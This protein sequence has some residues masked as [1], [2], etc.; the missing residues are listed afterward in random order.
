MSG[1]VKKRL[2]ILLLS[3]ACALAIT[4]CGKD[5]EGEWD[6]KE[7]YAS[8][9]KKEAEAPEKMQTE[10]VPVQKSGDAPLAAEEAPAETA[11]PADKEE[12]IPGEEDSAVSR[13]DYCYASMLTLISRSEDMAN[14]LGIG[15]NDTYLLNSD[16]SKME[17]AVADI[18]GDGVKELLVAYDNMQADRPVNVYRFGSLVEITGRYVEYLREGWA[19]AWYDESGQAGIIRDSFYSVDASV[20]VF[21]DKNEFTEWMKGFWEDISS[22]QVDENTPV[23]VWYYQY[24]SGERELIGIFNSEEHRARLKEHYGETVPLSWLPMTDE[25][26]RALVRGKTENTAAVLAAEEYNTP[27][28]RYIYGMCE[29][30]G[31]LGNSEECLRAHY[32]E[33]SPDSVLVNLMFWGAMEVEECLPSAKIVSEEDNL[34]TYRV[35]EEDFQAWC[36]NAFA[37]YTMEDLKEEEYF[38]DNG[39]GTRQ[40]AIDW[41]NGDGDFFKC[42]VISAEKRGNFIL[43]KGVVTAHYGEYADGYFIKNGY[44]FE[45]KLE[46]NPASLL[47]GYRV[48]DIKTDHIFYITQ[49]NLY[50]NIG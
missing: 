27:L 32:K 26:I 50:E 25:N 9:G 16:S 18:D 33:Y 22:V 41:L 7:E 24:Q 23:F 34:V 46:E 45:C 49:D 20:N 21:T 14:C 5:T 44:Y 15:R 3:I 43:L 1:E 4:A 31:R 37:F 10:E 13:E 12:E 11:V 6:W 29:A 28:A 42:D 36:E 19:L 2:M 40:M 30:S 8:E 39:D 38:R 47:S 17:F 35:K 48:M